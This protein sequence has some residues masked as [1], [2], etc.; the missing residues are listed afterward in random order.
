MVILM[1]FGAT[2][3]SEFSGNLGKSWPPI[4]ITVHRT[5]AG[6]YLGE[7]GS[8]ASQFQIDV[9]SLP[10]S[11]LPFNGPSCSYLDVVFQSDYGFRVRSG[12]LVLVG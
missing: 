12:P 6:L 8:L 3:A 10:A 5:N 1:V 4:W 2:F 7:S 11:E 9:I